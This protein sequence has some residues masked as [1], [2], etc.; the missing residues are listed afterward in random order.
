MRA[1]RAKVDVIGNEKFAFLR[2]VSVA[3]KNLPII[4]RQFCTTDQRICW[5][6]GWVPNKTEVLG[7]ES[8]VSRGKMKT[9]ARMHHSAFSKPEF[10]HLSLVLFSPKHMKEVVNSFEK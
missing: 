6:H 5:F 1:D 4:T 10:E 9:I 2:F 8:M 7:Q 3:D